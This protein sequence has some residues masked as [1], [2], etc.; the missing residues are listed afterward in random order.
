MSGFCRFVY[1]TRRLK[2]TTSSTQ[3]EMMSHNDLLIGMEKR[4]SKAN[5]AAELRMYVQS[6]RCRRIM[7][8]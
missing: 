7:D 5:D 8:D 1:F 3:V 2:S 6:K 4:L